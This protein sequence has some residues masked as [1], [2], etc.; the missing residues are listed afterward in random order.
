M[1]SLTVAF[2][3]KIVGQA[4][5]VRINAGAFA[6]A[7]WDAWFQEGMTDL[8]RRG[9]SLP[10]QPV[11]FV[12]DTRRERVFAGAFAPG[13]DALS[14]SF[15]AIVSI[16]APAPSPEGFVSWRRHLGSF[17]AAAG[18]LAMHAS[19]LTTAE[20]AARLQSLAAILDAPPPPALSDSLACSSLAELTRREALADLAYGLTTAIAACAEARAGK[21]GL[22]SRGLTHHAESATEVQRDFWIELVC[23]HL[24]QTLPS[25]LWTS[26]DLVITLGPPPAAALASLAAPGHAGSRFWPL[27]ASHP[28]ALASAIAQLSP[29]QAHVLGSPGASL[30]HVLSVFSRQPQ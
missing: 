19:Q 22:P 6:Q 4:D 26:Q 24:G 12:L 20:L 25:L 7:G 21:P 15:P 1:P 30:A 18:C 27:H 14:R 5:Y 17:F 2:Y 16:D 9:F 8:Q 3:G 10:R 13:Q 23:R 29:V 28:K 11:G